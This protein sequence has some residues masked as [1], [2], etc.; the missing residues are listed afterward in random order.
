MKARCR[1]PCPTG[2]QKPDAFD[3]HEPDQD[4]DQE[5]VGDEERQHQLM[6]GCKGCEAG[7]Q[8]KGRERRDKGQND[9]DRTGPERQRAASAA[10]G[11]HGIGEGQF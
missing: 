7:Q 6:D 5:C 4:Q 8:Q 11:F 3:R 2:A 9:G 1:L 10:G